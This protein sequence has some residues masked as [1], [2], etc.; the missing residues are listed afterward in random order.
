METD[1]I[2]SHHI[3]WVSLCEHEREDFPKNKVLPL[4]RD[5]HVQAVLLG[6]AL[7]HKNMFSL[8]ITFIYLFLWLFVCRVCVCGGGLGKQV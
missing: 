5:C 8:N 1:L 7:E 2:V 6:F 4:T 3:L